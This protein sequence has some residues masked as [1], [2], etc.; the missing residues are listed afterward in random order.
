MCK[1][2]SIFR[3]V[4]YT[5]LRAR[6]PN[7]TNWV[8]WIRSEY[9]PDSLGLVVVQFAS[10]GQSTSILDWIELDIVLRGNCSERTIYMRAI[11][12]HTHIHI[13]SY[14]NPLRRVNWYELTEWSIDRIEFISLSVEMIV[15]NMQVHTTSFSI[16]CFFSLQNLFVQCFCSLFDFNIAFFYLEYQN[17]LTIQYTHE[18]H[19]RLPFL[20][21]FHFHSVYSSTHSRFAHLKIHTVSNV[22]LCIY[23]TKERKKRTTEDEIQTRYFTITYIDSGIWSFSNT[24]DVVNCCSN[25]LSNLLFF[26]LFLF[27]YHLPINV[28]E[29]VCVHLESG[30]EILPFT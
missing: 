6:K 20:S 3:S 7:Q 9:E 13:S 11:N 23:H 22:Y 5:Y 1:G 30:Y 27:F 10:F 16:V 25:D 8:N 17:I 21:L 28:C 4:A 14:L 24:I 19:M 18:H 29:C 15:V 2:E 26:F 12:A